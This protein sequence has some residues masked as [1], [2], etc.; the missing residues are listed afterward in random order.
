MNT[1]FG[2]EFDISETNPAVYDSGAVNALI[3]HPDAAAPPVVATTFTL[4]EESTPIENG[5]SDWL[6]AHGRERG[7]LRQ[8]YEAEGAYR[9]RVRNVP[10]AVTP[11]AISRAVQG[12]ASHAGLAPFWISVRIFFISA[13]VSA[14]TT[15]GP[16]V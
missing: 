9:L 11:I 6:S 16:R 15:R 12:A 5:S 10:D 1:I 2:P 3:S 14:L 7:Q 4:V 13:L 8:A